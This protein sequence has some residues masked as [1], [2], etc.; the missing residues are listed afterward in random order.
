MV[1]CGIRRRLQALL[2]SQDPQRGHC[3]E[4]EGEIIVALFVVGSGDMDDE[5]FT[6]DAAGKAILD[7]LDGRRNLVRVVAAHTPEFDEAQDGAGERDALDLVAEL[8]QRRMLV[9]V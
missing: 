9:A 7:K 2:Q 8:V 1:R 6:C 4:I 3:R 5:L